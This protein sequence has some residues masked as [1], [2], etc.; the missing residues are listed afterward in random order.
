M[1]ELNTER[2]RIVCLD[3]ENFRLYI[4]EYGNMQ[5]NIAVQVISRL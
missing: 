4:H 3:L 1:L 2:L 5:R